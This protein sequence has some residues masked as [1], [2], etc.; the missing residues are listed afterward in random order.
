[1]SAQDAKLDTARR[2]SEQEAAL[3]AVQLL[4]ER[5][6]KS[7]LFQTDGTPQFVHVV[8]STCQPGE[9]GWGTLTLLCT[10]LMRYKDDAFALA[11]GAAGLFS[12]GITCALELVSSVSRP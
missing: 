10:W 2:L 4:N 6:A 5:L 11:A 9:I 7:T 8:P 3:T 1:M 12:L